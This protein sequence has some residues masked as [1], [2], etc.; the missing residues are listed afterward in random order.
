MMEPMSQESINDDAPLREE[1]VAYLDGELDVE[2]SRQVVQRAAAEPRARRILAGFER[3]WDLLDELES[4]ATSEDFTCT[5][6]E[7]VALA[8][9]NDIA[10]AKADAPRRRRRALLWTLAGLAGAAA[11]GFLLVWRVAA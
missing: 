7:M 3:T 9:E 8:A 6:L 2:Q 11:L 4:P 1:L 5:T 10:K